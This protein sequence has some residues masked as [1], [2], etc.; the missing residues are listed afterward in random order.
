MQLHLLMKKEIKISGRYKLHGKID[1]FTGTVTFDERENSIY[2]SWNLRDKDGQNLVNRS[3]P[4]SFQQI[5][6]G[7]DK[8]EF[9]K[10]H[11]IEGIRKYR[12]GREYII[13]ELNVLD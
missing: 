1:S 8:Y 11:A 9:S 5:P 7:Q 12:I 3:M 10:L 2:Y 4:V 13:Q 6:H